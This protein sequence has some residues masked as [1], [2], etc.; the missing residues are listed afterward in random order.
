MMFAEKKRMS[1]IL[2]DPLYGV[3]MFMTLYDV[4]SEEESDR[5]CH[6]MS[7]SAASPEGPKIEN[8]QSRLKIQSRLKN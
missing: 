4:V 5:N 7:Q 2:Y 3:M 8:V 1:G 6:K